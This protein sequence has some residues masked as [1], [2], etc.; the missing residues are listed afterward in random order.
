MLQCWKESPQ[1]RP[2]FAQ[3]HQ[4]TRHLQDQVEQRG[5][6]SVFAAGQRVLTSG[7]GTSGVDG[8]MPTLAGTME[9]LHS[10]AVLVQ[11]KPV[12]GREEGRGAGLKR[13]GGGAKERQ[14]ELR[15]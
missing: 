7:R 13:Q 11:S 1:D 5:Y 12:A 6:A 2:S 4:Q 3:M 15:Q 9:P 10:Y 14:G 8:Y